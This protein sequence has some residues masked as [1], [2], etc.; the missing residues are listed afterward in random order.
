MSIDLTTL[1]PAGI[2]ADIFR[3]DKS[4]FVSESISQLSFQTRLTMI[5]TFRSVLINDDKFLMILYTPSLIMYYS[6]DTINR[7]FYILIAYL[8][9]Y[10]RHKYDPLGL[11]NYKDALDDN[12]L[13]QAVSLRDGVNIGGIYNQYLTESISEI[14]FCDVNERDGPYIP[15]DEICDNPMSIIDEL[16]TRDSFDEFRGMLLDAINP[17]TTSLVQMTAIFKNP[18]DYGY[19]EGDMYAYDPEVVYNHYGYVYHYI[20]DAIL[21]FAQSEE[22]QAM[23]ERIASEIQ[24]EHC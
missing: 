1:L 21:D 5:D 9:Y 16:T 6:Q 12:W 19:D 7:N 13:E 18:L 4:L 14:I 10:Y 11:N 2:W 17:S 3:S 8:Y 23:K 20:E 15:V 22:G 24:E